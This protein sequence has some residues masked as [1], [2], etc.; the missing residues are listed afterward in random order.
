MRRSRIFVCNQVHHWHLIR[1][2][3]PALPKVTAPV[4]GTVHRREREG[5][6][7]ERPLRVSSVA[8]AASFS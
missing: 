2:R 5:L 8:K 7:D 3:Q 4:F 6:C 1:Q